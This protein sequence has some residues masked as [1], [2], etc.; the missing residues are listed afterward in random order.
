MR[1]RMNIQTI[2]YQRLVLMLKIVFVN[3]N[4]MI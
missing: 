1:Y 3:A 4:K 2:E